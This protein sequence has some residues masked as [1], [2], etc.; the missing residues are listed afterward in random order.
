[1]AIKSNNKTFNLNVYLFFRRIGSDIQQR[2][3]NYVMNL[4][5]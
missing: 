4:M 3:K 5:N 2:L 1:M